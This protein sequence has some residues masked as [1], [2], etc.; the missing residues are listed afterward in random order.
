MRC[1]Q[2]CH[3]VRDIWLLDH[4]VVRIGLG[5]L[6]EYLPERLVEKMIFL[7]E[8]GARLVSGRV[9]RKSCNQYLVGKHF[10]TSWIFSLSKKNRRGIQMKMAWYRSFTTHPSD[11]WNSFKQERTAIETTRPTHPQKDI[12]WCFISSIKIK[13][14]GQSEFVIPEP[15]I[16]I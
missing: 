2:S 9:H 15:H 12:M 1:F 14:K 13:E 4:V 6:T 7:L 10:C 5:K 16:Y 11:H 3:F 8:F